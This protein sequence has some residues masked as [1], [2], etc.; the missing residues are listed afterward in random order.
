MNKESSLY[1]WPAHFPKQCPPDDASEAMGKLFRLI[2]IDG[3][4]EFDFQ[5]PYE[6]EPSGGRTG[7][8]CLA[9][10]LSVLRTQEDLK[11]AIPALRKKQVAEANLALGAGLL[12][13][14]PSKNCAGHCTWWRSI[15][16]QDACGLFVLSE[17]A[18]AHKI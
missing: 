3:P 10:G 18:E 4:K 2:S 17:L 13:E 7:S 15:T 8:E 1:I 5:S 16:V 11:E 6:R 12:K 9:R 14:T